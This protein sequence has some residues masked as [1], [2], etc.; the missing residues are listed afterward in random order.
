MANAFRTDAHA[1]SCLP[2]KILFYDLLSRKQIFLLDFSFIEK[3]TFQER[4]YYTYI[5]LLM[6]IYFV[7]IQKIFLLDFYFIEKPTFQQRNYYLFTSYL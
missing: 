4:N 6:H 3:S 7:I 1:D 5:S 2:G